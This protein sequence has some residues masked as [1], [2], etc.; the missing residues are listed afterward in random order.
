MPI[1]IRDFAGIQWLGL[2]TSNSG[3]MD[4]IPGQGK[5]LYAAWHGQK[6]LK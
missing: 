1:L 3:S 2:C 4:L 6:I 5:V